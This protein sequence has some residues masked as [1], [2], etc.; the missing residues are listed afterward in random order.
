MTTLQRTLAVFSVLALSFARTGAALDYYVD[1]T[2]GNNGNSGTS[3]NEAW[4]TVKKAADTVRGPATVHVRGGPCY[5]ANVAFNEGV[6]GN[7]SG[8]CS[9]STTTGCTVFRGEDANGNPAPVVVKPASVTA[10][11]FRIEKNVRNVRFEYFDFVVDGST[12]FNEPVVVLGT[13]SNLSFR[14]IRIMGAHNSG[15]RVAGG[16]STMNP[17]VYDVVFEQT[18]VDGTR[19]VG[20]Q[21]TT[22]SK[23]CAL[24]QSIDCTANEAL[25]GADGPC[26][27]ADIHDVKFRRA[28]A[29]GNGRVDPMTGRIVGDGFAAA[30]THSTNQIY[31]LTFDQSHSLS[32]LDDGFDIAAK[33]SHQPPQRTLFLDVTAA[34]NGERG[35]YLW[36]SA[37]IENAW[38]V[39]NT[40]P[41]IRLAR[42]R[43]DSEDTT[44]AQVTIVSSTIAGNGNRQISLEGRGGFANVRVFNTIGYSSE[45]GQEVVMEYNRAA[46]SF[47]ISWD[48][49]L[50]YRELGQ[51]CQP[52]Q[53]CAYVV[54]YGSAST[55]GCNA[56][57]LQACDGSHPNSRGER[58]VFKDSNFSYQRSTSPGWNTGTDPRTIPQLQ[59]IQIYRAGTQDHDNNARPLGGGY[60]IGAFE[61]EGSCAVLPASKAKRPHWLAFGLV[62]LLY[63]RR[64][65]RAGKGQKPS[66]V[67]RWPWGRAGVVGSICFAVFAFLPLRAISVPPP[68]GSLL[69]IVCAT[70]TVTCQGTEGWVRVGNLYFAALRDVGPGWGER[71]PLHCPEP[72]FGCELWVWDGEELRLVKDINPN[73]RADSVAE[74]IQPVVMN[75]VLYFL[76]DDGEHGTELW[77]SDGT[78][79]GTYMVKDINPAP[80]GG[81]VVRGVHPPVQSSLRRADW[82]WVES[83]ARVMVAFRDT[84]IFLANDGQHGVEVW[85]SDG[86]EEGTF[87]LRDIRPGPK[88]SIHTEDEN[89]DS[90]YFM[91]SFTPLE[92]TLLFIANDGETGFELWATDG[93]S[94]GTR[95]VKDINRTEHDI[96]LLSGPCGPAS[97]LVQDVPGVCERARGMLNGFGPFPVEDGVAYFF[98]DD[99]VHGIRQWRSDGTPEGT[100]MVEDVGDGG[101][102]TTSGGTA[103]RGV[104]YWAFLPL[105][106]LLVRATRRSTSLDLDEP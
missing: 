21:L 37:H 29:T 65:A 25:C 53:S 71:P 32:N 20:Y 83:D 49:N 82:K 39:R 103:S 74:P 11:G 10:D 38:L 69:E 86:T 68:S 27:R 15:F 85:R 3:P 22:A 8:D 50:F 58:P 26:G 34:S 40:G 92:H 31:N 104:P 76:A 14:D 28:Y 89:L 78:E 18:W 72:R 70:F 41:G 19:G 106:W 33:F 98:A 12:V 79:R 30:P 80:K 45:P 63:A 17:G 62:G 102:H 6:S 55:D 75:D 90:R 99:G 81:G 4:R 64:G 84:L 46:P 67:G 94:E 61:G 54:K 52:H 59:G 95:L 101:C 1:C 77:R 42:V 16:F 73:L 100:F 87:L 9:L 23:V 24:K 88:S 36:H 60:E 44:I 13:A 93:T 105:A 2:L 48:W 43:R 7:S 56:S 91:P 35:L 51:G 47:S 5:E 96:G 66:C 97:S 57:A